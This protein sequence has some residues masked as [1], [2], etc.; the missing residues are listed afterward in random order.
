MTKTKTNKLTKSQ[1]KAIAALT[2][3]LSDSGMAASFKV[4]ASK[5]S[6]IVNLF[7][8]AGKMVWNSFFTV[9]RRGA[10]AHKGGC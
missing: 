9:G 10:V 1:A 5:K 7:D 2:Q 6:A 3:V 4:V 8:K